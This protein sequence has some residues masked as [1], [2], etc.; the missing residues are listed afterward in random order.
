M[1]Y[2]DFVSQY[3]EYLRADG[4]SG[5]HVPE[6]YVM[7]N[8]LIAPRFSTL[9][10]SFLA[11]DLGCGTGMLLK[12]LSLSCPTIQQV[13]VDENEIK[14]K[15][16]QLEN[17]GDFHVGNVTTITERLYPLY[18]HKI[19]LM[20]LWPNYFSSVGK[21]FGVINAAITA[22]R[23]TNNDSMILFCWQNDHKDIL[24]QDVS[25]LIHVVR[26]S[27]SGNGGTRIMLVS[28]F[29]LVEFIASHTKYYNFDKAVV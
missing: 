21:D 29:D 4:Y 3:G 5:E 12:Y 25:R 19:D 16:A 17:N 8:K 9:D 24:P 20:I 1:E 26:G 27:W 15:C 13:G 18:G 2:N 28:R 10:R 14:I 22:S 11:I 23:L 7:L 6:P